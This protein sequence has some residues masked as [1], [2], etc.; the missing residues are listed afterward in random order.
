MSPEVKEVLQKLGQMDVLVG[1]P[2]EKSSRPEGAIGGNYANSKITNSELIYI[3]T[4][5]IRQRSMIAE[6]QPNVNALGYNAAFQMYLQAHGSPLWQSPPRPIIE[7]AIEKKEN[8][9]ILGEELGKAAQKALEGDAQSAQAQ[10][11]ITG[12]TAQNIVRGWWD[13][14]ENNWPA[15]TEETIENKGSSKPL[16]DTG[17]LRKS[18]TYIVRDNK[19]D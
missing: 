12:M 3:H 17:E 16:V 18:I 11:E 8:K 2:E 19:N 9:R 6:M 5:G 4:H 13:D 15:N 1:V 10:L 7:P 14:P